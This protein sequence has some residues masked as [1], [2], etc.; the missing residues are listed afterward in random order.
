MATR[1]SPVRIASLRPQR[2]YD[3]ETEISNALD[4]SRLLDDDVTLVLSRYGASSSRERKR[5]NRASSGAR[6]LKTE[7]YVTLSRESNAGFLT[8]R[9]APAD[10]F[11]N[12]VED[13]GYRYRP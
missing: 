7:T 10:L 4:A 9:L 5:R 2:S 12:K 13:I 6:A 11:D 1:P 8:F 3:Y